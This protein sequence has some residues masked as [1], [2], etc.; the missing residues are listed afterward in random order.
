[1]RDQCLEQGVN[2]SM[3][4]A[5]IIIED[6]H[7]IFRQRG[8]VIDKQSCNA[9]RGREVGSSEQ[10]AGGSERIRRDYLQGGHQ[11]SDKEHQLIVLF[12]EGEPGGGALERLHPLGYQGRLAKARRCTHK[13]S[14]PIKGHVQTLDELRPR[15]HIAADVWSVKLGVEK[16]SGYAGRRYVLLPPV[17]KKATS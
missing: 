16:G 14:F 3:T 8:Q 12:I 10:A 6:Q 7:H 4:Y 13:G 1:M 2:I 17:L 9:V 5:V 15:D 11:G